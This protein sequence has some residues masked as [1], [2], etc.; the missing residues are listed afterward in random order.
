MNRIG[1]ERLCVFGMPP[2]E[3]VTLAADLG[4][5]FIGIGLTPISSASEAA[6]PTSPRSIPI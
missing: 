4:C 1:I 6:W 2:V 3:F 5:S